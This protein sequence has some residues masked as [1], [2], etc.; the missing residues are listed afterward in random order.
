MSEYPPPPPVSSSPIVPVSTIMVA[1]SSRLIRR[2]APPHDS[3]TS[4]STRTKPSESLLDSSELDR[5]EAE[6]RRQRRSKWPARPKDSLVKETNRIVTNP[7]DLTV[8]TGN[9]ESHGERNSSGREAGSS[10][11]GK[12]SV[13]SMKQT[14]SSERKDTDFSIGI[15]DVSGQHVHEG[16]ERH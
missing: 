11:S 9:D 15:A 7:E 5:R 6:R 2:H 4:R 14:F 1:G 16:R 3:H 13:Q 10:R 12:N 8:S